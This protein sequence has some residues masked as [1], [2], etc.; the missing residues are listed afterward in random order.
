MRYTVDRPWVRSPAEAAYP[1]TPPIMM[2]ATAMS[3]WRRSGSQPYPRARNRRR[4]DRIANSSSISC[5]THDQYNSCGPIHR[6]EDMGI[7]SRDHS[8]APGVHWVAHQGVRLSVSYPQGSQWMNVNGDGRNE[9]TA[10]QCRCF[11]RDRD[12]IRK[13]N[14]RGMPTITHG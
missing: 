1:M 10:S 14:A 11:A 8:S 4:V 6:F 12:G 7:T 2:I 13:E 9:K 5:T 3:R